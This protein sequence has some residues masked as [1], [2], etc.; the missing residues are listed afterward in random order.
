VPQQEVYETGQKRCNCTSPKSERFGDNSLDMGTG[1]DC[2]DTLSWTENKRI[3]LQQRI[4]RILLK[5][6]MEKH[7][8]KNYS[9]EWW[10]FTLKD[11]PFPDTYFN[12]VIE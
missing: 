11:E 3:G 12:F 8:F 2:F 1:Y 9:K 6:L 5:A 10:H 4:N 7:G